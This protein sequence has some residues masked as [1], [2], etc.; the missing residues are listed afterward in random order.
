M[1]QFVEECRREW[2]RLRVPDDVADE[3]AAEL[4]G[5]LQ[6]ATLEGAAPAD[7]LGRSASDPRAFA[8]AWADERGVT[9]ARR[10][11]RVL[12][13]CVFAALV[14]LAV[15]GAVLLSN[16][17]SSSTRSQIEP[18]SLRSDEAAMKAMWTATRTGNVT[19]IEMPRRVEVLPETIGGSDRR[20][21]GLAL[22]I[23]GLAGLV[24]LAAGALARSYK[25]GTHSP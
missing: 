1:N 22:L 13:F 12:A 23:A 16:W 9:S 25:L 10:V 7:L 18:I 15:S 19:T 20:T 4:A 8:R 14:G 21:L 2:K 5:D 6:Q 17:P 24:P 3:M 11:G